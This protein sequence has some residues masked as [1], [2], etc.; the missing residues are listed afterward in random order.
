MANSTESKIQATGAPEQE[1]SC[2]CC[3]VSV[4]LII[5][6]CL[7]LISTIYTTFEGT[8]SPFILLL[9]IAFYGFAIAGI[10][11]QRATWLKIV[12]WIDIVGG[13]ISL[14]FMTYAFLEFPD[15]F[16]EAISSAEDQELFR[17]L[18]VVF[19][20]LNILLQGL[21]LFYLHRLYSYLE[22]RDKAL[23]PEVVV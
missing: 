10:T 4:G 15:K 9:T 16:Y 11:Q 21:Y 8:T 12:F 3:S 19:T 7:M 17:I 22:R 20:G 18:L 2:C 1:P 5:W 13:I 6:I 23:T 14:A